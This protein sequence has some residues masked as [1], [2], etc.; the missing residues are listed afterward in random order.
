VTF[1]CFPVTTYKVSVSKNMYVAV[2]PI[3]LLHT[4]L[5]LKICH[6]FT[7]LDCIDLTE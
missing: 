2:F 1:L 7:K 6:R 5:N 3:R 4:V